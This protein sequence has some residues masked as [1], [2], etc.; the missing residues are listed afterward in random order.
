MIYP[1][2][3]TWQADLGQFRKLTQSETLILLNTDREAIAQNTVKVE[4]HMPSHPADTFARSSITSW[5]VGLK[6]PVPYRFTQRAPAILAW[7]SAQS[8]GPF[9]DGLLPGEWPGRGLVPAVPGLAS[10]RLRRPPRRL[11]CRPRGAAPRVDSRSSR[12]TQ[13]GGYCAS[14][15]RYFWGLRL[16]LVATLGGLPVTFAVTGA[17]SGERWT[18][19]GILAAD[20]ALPA[21][22]PRQFLIQL[23]QE[24]AWSAWSVGLVCQGLVKA[25]SACSTLAPV[26][27]PTV[28][29]LPLNW[30][31]LRNRTVDLLLTMAI[32]GLPDQATDNPEDHFYLQIHGLRSPDAA[33]RGWLMAPKNGPHLRQP[34]PTTTRRRTL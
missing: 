32:R 9:A 6:G 31:P 4:Y 34:R 28:R 5:R 14:H 13:A 10:V 17:K 25:W 22:R 18:L 29:I 2:H 30:S 21:G 26:G 16:Y 23:F 20:P 19:L 7:T 15:S 27:C 3:A 33:V 12:T 11:A 1:I 24:A 8:M